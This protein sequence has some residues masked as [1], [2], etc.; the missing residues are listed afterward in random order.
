MKIIC[1]KCQSE[2]IKTMIIIDFK[3]HQCE[4][5]GNQ[6]KYFDLNNKIEVGTHEKKAV[7]PLN[8]ALYLQAKDITMDE[9]NQWCSHIGLIG[10]G[11]FIDWLEE[12]YELVKKEK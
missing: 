9:K 7:T 6:Q 4:D 3:F 5:C 2:K 12:N 8:R 11:I 10:I 1:N